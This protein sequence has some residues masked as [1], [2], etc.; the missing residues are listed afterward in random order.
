MADLVAAGLFSGV[1]SGRRVLVTGHTGFKGSWLSLW[2]TEMGAHVTG[3]SLAPGTDPN[4]FSLLQLPMKSVLGDVRDG[5]AVRLVI[6]ESRPEI[7]F[8][9]AAQPLVGLSYDQPLQTW[10]TNVMGSVHLYLALC[11]CASVRAVVTITTD[12][13][14][15]NRERHWG[16]RENDALGGYDPYSASKAA[17]EILTDSM[18]DSYFNVADFGNKHE[19]LI[20]TARSGNVIGGGDW[21]VDRLLPDVIRA[22]TR[23]EELVIRSPQAARPWQHLLEPLSGYL[24]LAQR[25]WE[26]DRD[27]AQAFNFGPLRGEK[28][29]VE[30][31]MNMVAKL[32][33]KLNY[34]MQDAA[35]GYHETTLLQLDSG[36]AHDALNWRQ[37]WGVEEAIRQTLRW[38]QHHFETGKARSTDV[39]GQ[40]V[41][42]AEAI[43][44]P[45]CTPNKP[46]S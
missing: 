4:H 20:A 29:T 12:K 15:Q 45:W 27:A 31:L 46:A 26:G 14:Y 44:A 7:V 24:L 6:E 17:L 25:L 21:G 8:H 36:K 28:Y 38:H 34:R 33:P 1:F 2:L 22:V 16:Y 13:V 18:R 43:D 9:L 35:G 19:T 23:E 5:E 30:R 32:W 42:A 10:Q 39:I 40:Y 37:V 41:A 11:G 3:F